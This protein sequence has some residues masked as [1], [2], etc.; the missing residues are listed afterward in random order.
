MATKIDKQANN[1]G[2]I[3]QNEKKQNEKKQT[4]TKQTNKQKKETHT[5]Q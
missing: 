2:R 1:Y 3:V 5:I 4:K